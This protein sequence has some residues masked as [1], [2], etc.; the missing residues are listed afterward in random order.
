MLLGK[1]SYGN[2][3]LKDN[4]AIKSFNNINYLISEY[5]IL[6]FLINNDYFVKPF[7]LDLNK[8]ELSME[9]YDCDLKIWF[10][11]NKSRPEKI[12]NDILL[13][14]VEL[15]NRNLSHCDIKPSNILIRSHP[16]K[17][18][19]GDCGL[20]C[21]NKYSKI[22]LT[23]KNYRDKILIRDGKHDVFSFGLI[24]LQW[25]GNIKINKQYSYKKLKLLINKYIN[26]KSIKQLLFNILNSNRELR[27]TFK[28]IYKEL[29]NKNIINKYK[30]VDFI[31]SNLENDKRLYIRDLCKNNCLKYNIKR[32]KKGFMAIINFLEDNKLTNEEIEKYIYSTLFILNCN[33]GNSKISLKINDEYKTI[34]NK[35]LNNNNF[36]NI[37]YSNTQ[38]IESSIE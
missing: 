1:G 22:N 15:E 9:L 2:V 7:D 26:D 21:N 29:F 28:K 35:L 37:I 12:I 30:N 20:V 25:Y 18:V 16:L 6:K 10:E 4:K 31:E 27:P 38:I 5:G 11:I 23:S 13:G 36:I 34:I 17:A 24:L 33:F 8:L 19:I 14:L 32:G 3:Y